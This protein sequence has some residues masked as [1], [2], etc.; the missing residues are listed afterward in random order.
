MDRWTAIRV[1]LEHELG[2]PITLDGL[3]GGAA[4]WQLAQRAAG[5]RHSVDDVLTAW[6][7]LEAIDAAGGARPTTALDLGCGIGGVG[8]LVLWGLGPA[9]R[10]IAV[11]AQAISYRLLRANLA[12][13][14]LEARV[15]ARHGDLRELAVAD[16]LALIT[17]SPP[18]FPVGTGVLPADAQKAHARFELRG[19]I[20]DYA[21]AAA[22]HLRD[23]GVFVC[24]FPTAQ[25]ARALARLADGGL[26]VA[27]YRDVVPRVG[28]RPLFTLFACR[29]TGAGCRVDPPFEVRDQRGEVTAAMHEVR[30]RF[31]FA[32]G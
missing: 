18:Y 20:G 7:A 3:T 14:E 4:G 12:G 25:R 27:A 10:L 17:G 13:N 16:K 5:H 11:E 31:G 30:R 32:A 8:L 29:L 1:A 21:A 24:C 6:Y 26:H 9:A 22:R 2:E 15:D 19:D 28:L 23:D